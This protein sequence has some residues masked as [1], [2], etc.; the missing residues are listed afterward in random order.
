M[1]LSFLTARLGEFKSVVLYLSISTAFQLI[2]WLVP[3]F[4]VSAVA[5]AF[6]GVF[7]GPLF[8]TAVVLMTKLLPRDL[9]V[10]T[11]GFATAFGGS[12]GAIFPFIIGAIS[13]A[14]GVKS[15][16]PVILALFV[17]MAMLWLCLPRAGK[18]DEEQE[19]VI[20]N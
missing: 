7:L 8:P 14:K 15:L 18:K 9:H 10:G 19:S 1:A 16:Q 12:G 17:L 11:I 2:F 3:S 5:V 20:S 6:L 4:V 13:Q